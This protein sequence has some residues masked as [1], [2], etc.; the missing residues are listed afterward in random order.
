MKIGVISDT[1]VPASCDKLPE[2]VFRHFQGVD[3]IL[4]AGDLVDTRVLEELKK[5]TP[6]V[7]AVCG[8]MDSQST[9]DLLPVKK[10]I[11]AGK[12][13]IGLTHGWGP[14]EHIEERIRKEFGKVDVIVFGH[15]HNPVNFKKGGILFFNPGSPTDTVFSAENTIGIIEVTDTIKAKIIKI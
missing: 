7:E 4:H 5:V 9:H 14:S 13:L 11:K 10:I 8:N 2:S 15:T 12:Y 6:W 3:M 1:H